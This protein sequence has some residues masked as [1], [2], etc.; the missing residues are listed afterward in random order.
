V[1]RP[2]TPKVLE[3]IVLKEMALIFNRVKERGVTLTV[4]TS[5]YTQLAIDAF[6]PLYG[7][8]PLRRVIQTKILTPL[9]EAMLRENVGEDGVV[10]ISYNKEY[11]FK[12]KK[13]KANQ[14]ISQG[15]R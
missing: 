15:V 1:F 7:A 5:V 6:D 3:S 11:Q 9:A 13:K 10:H 2:I 8:R 12:V 14:T 4:D